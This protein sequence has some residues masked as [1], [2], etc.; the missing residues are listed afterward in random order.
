MEV[1]GLGKTSLFA[2]SWSEWV[3]DSSRPVERGWAGFGR[4]DRLAAAGRNA[5]AGRTGAWCS[6]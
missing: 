5:L 3:S 2:G 6:V 1:A 4:F